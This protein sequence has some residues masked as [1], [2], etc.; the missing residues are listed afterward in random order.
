MKAA[1]AQRTTTPT[2]GQS[3]AAEILSMSCVL[4]RIWRGRGAR[5]RAPHPCCAG[6]SPG[7]P[8]RAARCR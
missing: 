6:R 1:T 8:A 5:T 2:H 4:P 3:R 7:S